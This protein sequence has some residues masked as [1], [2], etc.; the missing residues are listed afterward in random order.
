MMLVWLTY[1]DNINSVP[2]RLLRMKRTL[3]LAFLG[4]LTIAF[5]FHSDRRVLA[6]SGW[7]SGPVHIPQAHCHPGCDTSF[8]GDPV[9][10][11]ILAPDGL[12]PK[13]VH[14]LCDGGGC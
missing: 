2:E 7:K 1:N 12:D 13:T 8:N 11:N 14:L 5:G 4:L 9:P 10:I 6:A 3:V